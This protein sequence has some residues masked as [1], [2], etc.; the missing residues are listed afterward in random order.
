MKILGQ[1]RGPSNP[2]T[3][4]RWCCKQIGREGFKNR[5]RI[6]FYNTFLMLFPNNIQDRCIG[7]VLMMNSE[8]PLWDSPLKENALLL[9]SIGEKN[10]SFASL[11]SEVAVYE[12]D[13][14][15]Y[16][17]LQ[18]FSGKQALKKKKPPKRGDVNLCNQKRKVTHQ[19]FKSKARHLSACQKELILPTAV[20]T[21]VTAHRG[22]Q[23]FGTPE[24]RLPWPPAGFAAVIWA[25][26][27]RQETRK[28]WLWE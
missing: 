10:Y 1:T 3:S 25:W 12:N 8:I 21:P 5:A 26:S 6:Y 24:T 2:I 4:L 20:Y 14:V 16:A 11:V 28:C 22:S 17:L 23:S 9:S 15:L 13:R 7:K 18:H 19:I 27:Q